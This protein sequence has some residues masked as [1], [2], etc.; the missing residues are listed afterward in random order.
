MV[1]FGSLK[2]NGKADGTQLFTLRPLA[3]EARP[4][5]VKRNSKFRAVSAGMSGSM[6]NRK[7]FLI[8]LALGLAIYHT[9]RIFR[10]IGG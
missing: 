3:P 5:H 7:W 10:R 6:T 1:F 9:G 8:G 4:G 2:N